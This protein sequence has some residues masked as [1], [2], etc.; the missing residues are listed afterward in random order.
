MRKYLSYI[1]LLLFAVSCRPYQDPA[2]ISDPRLQDSRYCND[3]AAINYN[4]NFPGIPDNSICFYPADVFAGNYLWRDTV[5]NDNLTARSFD[6]TYVTLQKIDT[7]G[8]K[9]SGKCGYEINITA[10]RFLTLIIDSIAGN[11]QLFCRNT[12]TIIGTGIKSSITDTTTFTLNYTIHSDTGISNH[13]A[14]FIKQ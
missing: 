3:P 9:L 6:S 14:L 2:P 5:L 8:L 12:D 11:G 7:V 4:W 13:K 1:I 10:D